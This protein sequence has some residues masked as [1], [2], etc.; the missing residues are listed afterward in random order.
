VL[1]AVVECLRTCKELL[2]C[3]NFAEAEATL[4][5]VLCLFRELDALLYARVFV[6]IT[7]AV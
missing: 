3:L 6:S 1:Q 4:D 5:K 7:F 2:R